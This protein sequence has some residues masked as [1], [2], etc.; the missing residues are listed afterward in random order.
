MVHQHIKTQIQCH[1]MICT[2]NSL[3]TDMQHI[4]S[5]HI[6]LLIKNL[7]FADELYQ[8]Y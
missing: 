4:T 3:L 5:V 7:V 6:N 8:Q 1:K 2:G